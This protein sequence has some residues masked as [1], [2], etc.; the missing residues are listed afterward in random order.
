MGNH[1]VFPPSRSKPGRKNKKSPPYP[2]LGPRRR[3]RLP[4]S[5]VPSSPRPSDTPSPS[6]SPHQ[7][8]PS[9]P[10]ASP[11][12]VCGRLQHRTRSAQQ[13]RHRSFARPA[14]PWSSRTP[15]LA[16]ARHRLRKPR[17]HTSTTTATGSVPY[18]RSLGVIGYLG[19]LCRRLR[20]RPQSTG[21]TRHAPLDPHG[22]PPHSSLPSVHLAGPRL[23]RLWSLHGTFRSPLRTRR[24]SSS[25][26]VPVPPRRYTF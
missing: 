7:D 26:P 25:G 5:P 1:R 10:T 13:R 6:H 9:Y 2:A 14:L 24:Y 3:D 21:R 8:K 23:A 20:L 4:S 15:R 18:K 17:S 12:H 22:M 11:A 16:A 19:V